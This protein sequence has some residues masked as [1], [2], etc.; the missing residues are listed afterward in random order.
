MQVLL[1]QATVGGKVP[2]PHKQYENRDFSFTAVALMHP[3]DDEADAMNALHE[4][5]Y[6]HF[7]AARALFTGEGKAA[8]EEM[9]LGLPKDVREQL[10]ATGTVPEYLKGLEVRLG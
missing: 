6:S 4:Y 9:W 10:L 2:S 1:I 7:R 3:D 5:C 8:V